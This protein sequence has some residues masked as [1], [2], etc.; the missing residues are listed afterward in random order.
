MKLKKVED[1]LGVS[2]EELLAE[3]K[4]DVEHNENV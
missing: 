1:Y 3:E 4:G 2:I